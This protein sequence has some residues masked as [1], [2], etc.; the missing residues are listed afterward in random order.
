MQTQSALNSAPVFTEI[1][2]VFL[3]PPVLVKDPI[4]EE[5]WAIKRDINAE[6]NYDVAKLMSMASE[7]AKS[8]KPKF[9]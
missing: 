2:S 1:G 9:N 6:A 8:L 4:L 7:V 3:T 5:L